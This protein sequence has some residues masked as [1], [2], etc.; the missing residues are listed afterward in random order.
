VPQGNFGLYRDDGLGT[1]KDESASGLERIAKSIRSTFAD[2]GF[3]ITIQTGAISTDFLDITLNLNEDT[4]RPFK[5][6]NANLRYVH[7]QSN[8]PPHVKKALPTMINKRLSL[9]SKDE[10]VFNMAK[11][12]YEEALK[13]SGYKEHTL[14]FSPT[15]D[16]SKPKNRRRRKKAIYFNAP[17]CRSV[18]T[19]IGREFFRIVDRHFTKDHPYHQILNRRTIK[20]SYSCMNNVKSAIQS[21]N[22]RL[23]REPPSTPS[24]TDKTCNCRRKDTCPLDGNCLVKNIIYKATVKTSTQEMEYIGSTGCT[25]KQRYGGHKY[26]FTHRKQHQSTELSKYVWAMKDKGEDPQISW[27][28][29]HNIRIPSNKPQRI[30]SLCNLERMEISEAKRDRTLNRRTELTGAC[31]HFRKLYF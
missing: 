11:M 26:S 20:L 18:K 22:A 17:F 6:P 28:V 31:V 5:K 15:N 30:C 14:S 3:G 29:L 10:D 1:I 23:L 4:Y 21:H 19:K 27:K 24:D 25:F 8:H 12:D 7:H 9:L 16:S 13:K 2:I